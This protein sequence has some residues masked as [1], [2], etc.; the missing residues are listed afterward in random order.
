MT[1]IVTRLYADHATAEQ[2][3]AALRLQNHPMENISVV[4]AGS[5][6]AADMVAAQVPEDS[7]D[8][9]ASAMKKG[10]A[11]VVCRAP[12][13]PFGAARNA[14]ATMDE[15]D[16]IDAGV[17]N[18]NYY[19]TDQEHDDLLI[20]MKVDRSH[21]YWATW[22]FELDEYGVGKKYP[23]SG[24]KH[25][26]SLFGTEPLDFAGKHWGSFFGPPLMGA[27]KHWGS[28]FGSP[29][30]GAG[31]HWGSFFGHPL[32]GAGKYWGSFFGHPLMG[33][34]KFWGTFAYD[35]VLRSHPYMGSFLIPPLTKRSSD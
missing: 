33:A 3:V 30:M 15:F 23:R 14:M 35:P 17:A 7:A 18:E 21:R 13:T 26:G 28:F 24:R 29:L 11:L 31:K 2:A 16:A 1:T 27:G 8:A 34:G 6:A 25:W 5:Q 4:Q 9:Y 22:K 10:N 19:Q 32:K 20:D 12:F